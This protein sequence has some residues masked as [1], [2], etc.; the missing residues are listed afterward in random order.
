LSILQAVTKSKFRALS[1]GYVLLTSVSAQG[2]P[3]IVDTAIVSLPSFKVHSIPTAKRAR[4]YVNGTL[5]SITLH[6]IDVP[7]FSYDVFQLSQPYGYEALMWVKNTMG[8][9]DHGC[10]IDLGVAGSVNVDA[11]AR[12]YC[13]SRDGWYDLSHRMVELGLAWP[14]QG[15][16]VSDSVSARA[17]QARVHQVG[18]W[19]DEDPLPPWVFRSR[20]GMVD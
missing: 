19:S 8:W 15:C 17:E 10:R 16:C 20:Q 18:L 7:Y 11:R 6:S 4:V 2:S 13:P 9:S 5:H 3:S 12:V 14:Q 1:V